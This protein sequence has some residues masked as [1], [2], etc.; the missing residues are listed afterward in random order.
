MFPIALLSFIVDAFFHPNRLPEA[1]SWRRKIAFQLFLL[2]SFFVS[3]PFLTETLDLF[4]RFSQDTEL[5]LERMPN[6]TIANGSIQTDPPLEQAIVVKTGSLLFIFDPLDQYPDQEERR[7]ISG[8]GLAL[9]FDESSFL[10]QSNE[11]PLEIDYTSAEGM[12]DG[13]FRG[14]L[15]RF[16]NRNAITI[17]I[18]ALFSYLTG[19]VETAI[20]FLF[21]T[22]MANIVAALMRRRFSF[23]ENWRM[24]MVAAFVPTVIFAI[25]NAFSLH[26]VGQLQIIGL[27]SLFLYYRGLR[28]TPKI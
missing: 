5:V 14:L 6:F 20:R 27:L 19:M 11:V 24:M 28:E 25:L 7:D 16:S 23:G 8:A 15:S 2:L 26:A 9:V 18:V 21:F 22:L 4:G 1:A 13:F 10:F 3:I 12:T 17:L